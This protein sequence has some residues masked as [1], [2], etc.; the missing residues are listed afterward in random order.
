MLTYSGKYRHFKNFI[1]DVD[2]CLCQGRIRA[3]PVGPGALML[4]F[5]ATVLPRCA[6]QCPL[7][8]P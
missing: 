4:G 7:F 6:V 8:I 5:R 2:T 1:I 3:A